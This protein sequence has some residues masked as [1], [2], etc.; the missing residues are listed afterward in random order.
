MDGWVGGW[1][2]LGG[3]AVTLSSDSMPYFV[4]P[5]QLVRYPAALRV[6]RGTGLVG[7]TMFSYL[8]CIKERV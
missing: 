3:A 6:V 5:T 1:I 7:I 8:E 4:V 2:Q